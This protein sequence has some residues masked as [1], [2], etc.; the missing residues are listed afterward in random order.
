MYVDQDLP[1]KQE[2]E[3]VVIIKDVIKAF[4]YSG[5]I[6]FVNYSLKLPAVFSILPPMLLLLAFMLFTRYWKNKK[7]Q[8]AFLIPFVAAYFGFCLY[9]Y[10]RGRLM[11]FTAA[12]M[13]AILA[14]WGVL[15]IEC[16]VR[17]KKRNLIGFSVLFIVALLAYFGIW[18][19]Y[20][21]KAESVLE[22]VVA[23]DA[24][25]DSLGREADALSRELNVVFYAK[26]KLTFRLTSLA[27]RG[28]VQEADALKLFGEYQ[29]GLA[30]AEGKW[31]RTLVREGENLSK[32]L[33]N[34]SETDFQILF[35]E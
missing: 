10:N 14:T 31:I 32:E 7:R 5:I 21:V 35:E 13:T 20:S 16:F 28:S 30:G 9:F 22:K 3:A 11:P 8:Y 33:E 1:E 17:D 27:D 34:L 4:F 25:E 23:A 6:H 26:P 19:Y 12:C 2:N 24:L 15:C 18:K 29:K